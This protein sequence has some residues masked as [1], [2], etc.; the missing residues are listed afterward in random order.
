MPLR[1]VF[2]AWLLATASCVALLAAW[3]ASMQALTGRHE[4]LVHNT[5]DLALGFGLVFAVLAA[6]WY[7]PV[8]WI[9]TFV[10]RRVPGYTVS[11]LTGA[12][13]APLALLSVAIRFQES[14]GPNTV[15]Q[16]ISYWMT[17]PLPFITGALPFA[18]A[19]ALFGYF[20]SRSM[21]NPARHTLY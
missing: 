2:A 13:F 9:L 20:W 6:L 8:F 18:G 5:V 10:M 16:W 7:V 1:R 11:A 15:A 4:H 12:V 17:H 21:R 3:A 14:E 19:G